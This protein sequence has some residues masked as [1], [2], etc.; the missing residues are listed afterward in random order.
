MKS[1]CVNP[2]HPTSL[3]FPL[4]VDAPVL[5]EGTLTFP[6]VYRNRKQEQLL[7]KQNKNKPELESR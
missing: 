2:Q 1:R 6:G 5:R 4:L 7:G 3:I